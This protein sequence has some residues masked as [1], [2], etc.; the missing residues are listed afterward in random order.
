MRDLSNR[1]QGLLLVLAILVNFVG[2]FVFLISPLHEENMVLKD[3]VE[4]LEI[5]KLEMISKT[6]QNKTFEQELTDT[7]DKIEDTLMLISD[8]IETEWYDQNLTTFAKDSGLSL[9]EIA[10]QN[11]ETAYPE[12]DYNEDESRLHY[13]LNEEISKLNEPEVEDS[14]SKTSEYEIVRHPVRLSFEGAQKNMASFITQLYGDKET[15]YVKDLSYDYEKSLGQVEL[16][17]Y[18]IT[19]TKN[20]G[21]LSSGSRP[22]K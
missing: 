1:E 10:Y 16:N 19:K 15:I 3:E 5:Q 13:E 18:S 11:K 12:V 8:P 9:N 2:G 21:I 17:I 7:H 22:S 4:I 20:N 6:S 14:E